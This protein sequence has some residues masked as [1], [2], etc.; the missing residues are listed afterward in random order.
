MDGDINYMIN[1]E[2]IIIEAGL[3]VYGGLFDGILFDFY[4]YSKFPII[5]ENV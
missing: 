3:W 5:K 4:V 2:L 1:C